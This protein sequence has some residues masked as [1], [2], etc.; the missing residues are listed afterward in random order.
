MSTVADIARRRADR[1]RVMNA[2]YEAAE[3]SRMSHVSG[4]WLLEHLEL[5]D[6]ELGGICRYLEGERLITAGREYW[7][8]H[9]PFMI[10]LT[11]AGIEEMKQSRQAPDQATEHFP[12][13]SVIHIEGDATG[14]AIQVGNPRAHQ[15]VFIGDL[16][17]D[18]VREIVGE[19]EAQAASLRLPDGDAT[20]L[21]ADMAAVKVQTGL[22]TPDRDT[23]AGHLQSA[24]T[25][26]EH[27]T[28]RA[29]AA[30]LI[31]LLRNLH[32]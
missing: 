23:I 26:L 3:G 30:G 32:L 18:T 17:L 1:L 22:P 19:F 31:D 29:A 21:R 9:T 24:R 12:P 10:L 20:Q 13:I 16:N 7:G 14:S 8:H 28:D 27:A 11:H 15:A 2:I 25:I 5:S 4:G 6:E